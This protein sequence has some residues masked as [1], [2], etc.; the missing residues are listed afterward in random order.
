MKEIEAK[1]R[2]GHPPAGGWL[3]RQNK[4][5]LHEEKENVA[6]SQIK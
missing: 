2:V 3:I 1:V 6:L 4:K 5:M